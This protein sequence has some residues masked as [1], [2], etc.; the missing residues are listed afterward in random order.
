MDPKQLA[1][2]GLFLMLEVVS[3]NNVDFDAT[4]KTHNVGAGVVTNTVT[5][6]NDDFEVGKTKTMLIF[7]LLKSK[8]YW[9]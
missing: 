4:N 3:K 5:L 9:S 6:N 7:K 8:Q 2:M 1:L